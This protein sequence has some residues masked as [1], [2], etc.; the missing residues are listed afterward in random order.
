MNHQ[1][2]N[3]VVR[4][5]TSRRRCLSVGVWRSRHFPGLAFCDE[6]KTDCCFPARVVLGGARPA[7]SVLAKSEPEQVA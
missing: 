3:G 6:H 5:G 7:P 4:N 2:C 1:S